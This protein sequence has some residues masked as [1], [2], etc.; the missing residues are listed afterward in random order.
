M[1]VISDVAIRF[2]LGVVIAIILAF[3]F[4]YFFLR[5]TPE[6]IAERSAYR[7]VKA[8]DELCIE[9]LSNSDANKTVDIEL[10]QLK[11]ASLMDELNS[12]LDELSKFFNIGAPKPPLQMFNDPYFYLYWETFPPENTLQASKEAG[13]GQIFLMHTTPEDIIEDDEEENN[14]S[15]CFVCALIETTKEICKLMP[16]P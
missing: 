16:P 3:C 5:T 15:N 14:Q 10:P 13:V 1:R 7:F 12:A 8:I 2:S 4:W 11:S 9:Y 6:D